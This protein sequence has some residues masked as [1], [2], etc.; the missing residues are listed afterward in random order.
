M[1][2]SGT[3]R[4]FHC[5]PASAS[6]DQELRSAIV[7]GLAAMPGVELVWAARQGAPDVGV[8][9]VASVWSSIEALHGAVGDGVAEGR[10]Q[11]EDHPGGAD[12]RLEMFPILRSIM[13]PAPSQSGILRLSRG[14]LREPDL[15][16]YAD[17][18][19]EGVE[20][21]RQNGHGP[22]GFVLAR[23]G[24]RAFVTVSAWRDWADI[25]VATGATIRDP[26]RTRR[27]AELAAFEAQHY[28]LI[29]G[30]G[31]PRG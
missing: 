7:P 9:V 16:R 24:E 1:R 21:D 11:P 23:A 19:A 27:T 3:L 29:T 18:V 26:I 5:R 28:E 12:P 13:G 8:R 17:G 25:E 15:D 10:V 4:L 6:F 31:S 2:A 20:A 30:V 14:E 22:Y